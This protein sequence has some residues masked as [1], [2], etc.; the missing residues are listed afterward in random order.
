MLL[1]AAETDFDGLEGLADL[2]DLLHDFQFPVAGGV[3]LGLGKGRLT[4]EPALVIC[5][6]WDHFI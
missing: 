3:G 4:Y 6:K 1:L 5:C 2:D